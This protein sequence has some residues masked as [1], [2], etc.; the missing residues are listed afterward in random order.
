MNKLRYVVLV[1]IITFS[2]FVFAGVDHSDKIEET[3][4][5]PGDVTRA[6]L[7][8]HDTTGED[9]IQTAHWLWK[10]KTRCLKNGTPDMELGKINLM[11]GF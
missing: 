1:W 4:E 8:C 7:E 3:L 6:C 9:F 5:T 10:G 2:S 11:N